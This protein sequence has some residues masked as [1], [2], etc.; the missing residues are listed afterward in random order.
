MTTVLS[1]CA[2]L[3]GSIGLLAWYKSDQWNNTS[4][5]A[6]AAAAVLMASVN[7]YQ[8]NQIAHIKVDGP[9]VPAGCVVAN[10]SAAH[11]I[12]TCPVRVQMPATV[13]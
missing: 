3:A 5:A 4:T 7:L 9:G 13:H 11:V 1:V 6:F 12:L 2:A 8:S 10:S